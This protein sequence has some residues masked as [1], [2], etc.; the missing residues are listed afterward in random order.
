M[1]LSLVAAAIGAAVPVGHEDDEVEG[2]ADPQNAT[3]RSLVFI[4]NPKYRDS[5][6]QCRARFVIV[7]TGALVQQKICLEVVD[8]YV[9]FAKAAALFEDIR[10]LLDNTIHSSSVIHSKA[11]IGPGVAIGPGTVI[12]EAS[13]IGEG[14][15][16]GAHCVIER[17]CSIGAHCRIDSG[18][19]IRH[20]TVIGSR[21]IIQANAVIGSDGFGNAWDGKCFVRIPQLGNVI[22]HDDAEIGAGT[23]IDRGALGSTVV[24]NGVK[25]D[26]LIHLAHNVTVG[27][28]SAIAAQTGVSGSVTIGK[29]VRIGGQAGFVGHISIG[30]DSIIGAQSGVTKEVSSKEIVSGTPA[31]NLMKQRRSEAVMQRLPELA[32]EVK[33]IRKELDAKKSGSD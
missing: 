17:N 32:R 11:S 8:P 4:S 15:F 20:N 19:I 23:C 21:V 18:V 13:M 10:P 1:K 3:D 24:G 6:V 26:N 25:L 33:Q 31:R 16:I 5:V 22:I 14:T 30:D 29:R 2:L 28:N 7:K 27:E 9:G 12:D